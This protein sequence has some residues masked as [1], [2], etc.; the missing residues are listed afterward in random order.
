[1]N[2]DIF[3]YYLRFFS[4]N[5]KKKWRIIQLIW[6]FISA[7]AHKMKSLCPLKTWWETF[8]LIS[9]TGSLSP[10][11]FAIPYKLRLCL[12]WLIFNIQ[13]F[14]RQFTRK[15]QSFLL[16][17]LLFELI[18]NISRSEK[19]SEKLFLAERTILSRVSNC[20]RFFWECSI[21]CGRRREVL[22]RRKLLCY[23]MIH[24]FYTK[25]KNTFDIFNDQN[26]YSG[27]SSFRG[28]IACNRLFVLAQGLTLSQNKK[29]L[30][31]NLLYRKD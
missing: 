2:Q 1:M 3:E 9:G 7:K 27:P 22:F 25:V 4:D 13:I 28:K 30:N 11:L 12:V 31:W 10:H 18:K 17:L 6:N 23:K 14:S 16:I 26:L 19:V 21:F 15:T 29:R 5:W 8:E 24:W 20:K